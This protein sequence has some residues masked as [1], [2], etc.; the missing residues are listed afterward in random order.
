MHKENDYDES[1][2]KDVVNLYVWLEMEKLTTDQKQT[3]ISF[4]PGHLKLRTLLRTQLLN[5]NL[6][7]VGTFH[8]LR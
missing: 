6:P 8:L 7:M 1:Y 2:C 5:K 3:Q 4:P